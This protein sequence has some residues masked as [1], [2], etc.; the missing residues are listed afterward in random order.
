V[1]GGR[2]ERFLKEMLFI[3]QIDTKETAVTDFT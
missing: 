3:Q 2:L 1:K